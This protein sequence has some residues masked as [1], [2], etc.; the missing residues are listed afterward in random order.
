[1]S[2]IDWN[3]LKFSY[4]QTKC[5]VQY[6]FKDG[7]WSACE[8]VEEP[9]IKMHVAATCLHYGQS[10][11][12]GLKAYRGEDGEVRVFRPEENA[13]RLQKSAKRLCME[14]VPT[15]IFLD[16][17]DKVLQSNIDFLPPYGYGASMY[18]R[19]LLIGSGPRIG[20]QPAEEYTFI[21]LVVPV[22]SYYKGGLQSV[23]ALVMED[24]DRAAPMGIGHVKAAGNYAA[25]MLPGIMASEQGYPINLYLDAK[26]HKYI[27]EFGTS[28]FIGIKGN[29]YVTP[30]SSSVLPSITNMSLMTLAEEMG[31]AVEKRDVNFDEITDFDGI[32]A[33]G[34]AVVVTPISHIDKL[35]KSYKPAQEGIHPR[36]QELY[37]RMQKIQLGQYQDQYNWCRIVSS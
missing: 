12:E 33:C 34:T 8:Y 35:G 1:M 21:M 13:K 18:M 14:P 28:N 22:G 27:D 26:E 25:A 31:M 37:E 11:F 32:A 29:T 19:P 15:E 23:P 17:V 7:Q 4:F 36:F 6:T 20:V 2:T 9:Y 3:D 10:A 16:A 30:S 24:Y 5:Y